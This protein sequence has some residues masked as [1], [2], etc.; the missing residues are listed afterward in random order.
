MEV[1][2]ETVLLYGAEVWGGSRILEWV[3]QVQMRAAKIFLGVGRLHPRV[4]LHFEMQLVPLKFE[5][6]KRCVEFWV[7]VLRMEGNRLVRMAMLEGLGLRGKVKWI[8][9]LKQSLEEIG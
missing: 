7:K 4:S 9:N 2:I 1:L 5:A 8:E 3:E 6:K